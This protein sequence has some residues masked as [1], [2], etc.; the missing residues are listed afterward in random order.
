LGSQVGTASWPLSLP[1]PENS[2]TMQP[3]ETKLVVFEIGE[4][5]LAFYDDAARKWAADPGIFEIFI[6]GSSHDLQ[7]AARVEYLG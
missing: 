7:V 6:G 1:T 4:A 3:G 2:A 5:A